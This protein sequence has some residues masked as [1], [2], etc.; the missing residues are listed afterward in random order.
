MAMAIN[1][2][3]MMNST[4]AVADGGECDGDGDGE[5]RMAR[6]DASNGAK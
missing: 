5:W 6:G 3:T 2:S 1:G 4:V